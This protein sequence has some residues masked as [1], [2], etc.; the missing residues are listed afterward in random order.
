MLCHCIGREISGYDVNFDN[1]SDGY[2][3]NHAAVYWK[4]W[5]FTINFPLSHIKML[6]LGLST[7]AQ[8]TPYSYDC[9][10]SGFPL[11]LFHHQ[12]PLPGLVRHDQHRARRHHRQDPPG[13]LRRLQRCLLLCASSLQGEN[14]QKSF[15][16]KGK[17]L[18]FV[19]RLN[20]KGCNKRLFVGI[21]LFDSHLLY[22]CVEIFKLVFVVSSF[23][24]S[25]CLLK[26]FAN[27]ACDNS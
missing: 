6:K 10:L 14:L 3:C 2:S 20:V 26:P 22:I 27:R 8:S 5:L 16:T 13:H 9:C 12:C 21:S 7:Q 17:Y 23:I 4:Y 1:S 25:D 15:V 11:L 18:L 24:K 19:S